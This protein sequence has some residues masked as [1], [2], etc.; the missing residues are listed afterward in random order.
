MSNSLKAR[1]I[2]WVANGLSL[3]E[4]QLSGL[5]E[6]PPREEMGD[7]AMPCFSFARTLHQAPQKIAERFVETLGEKPDFLAQIAANSGY[8]NFFFDRGAFAESLFAAAREKPEVFP[9]WRDLGEGRVT[10]V[11]YSS[12]NIAKPF[13]VGHGFSTCLGDSLARL[14]RYFGYDVYRLNHLGDYGTQ[15]GKLISAWKRW[16]DE[17]ALENNPIAELTRV[18]VKFHEEAVDNSA[19][20]DEARDYF[21][22]LENGNPEEKALWERFRSL[23]LK[24]FSRLYERLSIR[25]D[26]YNGESFYSDKIPAVVQKLEDAGLLVESEGAKVVMLDEYKL[27]PCLI[28]KSDGTTIYAS[29][30]LAAIFYR[31]ATWHFD[32]NIYVVGSEQKNHFAQVFGVLRK[33]GFAKWDRC[34]HVAFGRLRFAEGGEFS[35]RKGHVILLEDLLDRTR[36]KVRGIMAENTSGMSPEEVEATAEAIA[37]ASVK[38]MY[39]KSGREKDILFDW[40]EMLDFN[41]DTAPY[42]LYTYARAR[43]ILRKGEDFAGAAVHRLDGEEEFSLLK[44]LAELEG[45]AEE[46]LATAEPSTLTRSLIRLAREFNR[47]YHAVPILHSPDEELVGARLALCALVA[48]ELKLGLSLLGITTVER[49]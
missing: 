16:G 19:L 26:N 32:Q 17:E 7:L 31:D 41:G 29:R 35:T 36:D 6:K 22:R 45:S 4:D 10:I 18:Y 2:Q 11:E 20:E 44:V 49:M 15:F 48:Q 14:F 3:P 40:N 27:P 25:F 23:S 28:L 46:A 37:V 34:R 1:T 12:P 8:L 33:M 30:D 5:M 42:L 9:G 21:R 43:S 24:E 38:F 39:L 13:H 47:Y